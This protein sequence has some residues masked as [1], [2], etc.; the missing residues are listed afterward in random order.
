MV[1]QSWLSSIRNSTLEFLAPGISDRSS[2]LI[3]FGENLSFVPKPF[4]F[5]NFWC[6]HSDIIEEAWPCEVHES[7][8][9]QLYQKLKATKAS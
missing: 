7:P 5:L 3:S 9:F 2:A 1:N 6:D 4:K 8:M